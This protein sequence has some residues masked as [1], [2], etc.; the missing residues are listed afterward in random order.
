MTIT[1]E[2][3]EITHLFEGAA[4][5]L[6]N[7]PT[8]RQA[9]ANLEV[10]VVQVFKDAKTRLVNGAAELS[11]LACEEH[12]RQMGEA[13]FEVFAQKNTLGCV[14]CMAEKLNDPSAAELRR[15]E[16]I[17]RGGRPPITEVKDKD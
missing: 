16:A 3:A 14:W 5:A 7:D 15:L 1:E 4:R 12:A 11:G 6:G 10:R 2:L 13:G 17:V 9:L 8:A